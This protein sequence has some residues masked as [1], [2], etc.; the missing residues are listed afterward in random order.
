MPLAL[1]PFRV[2]LGACLLVSALVPV[3]GTEHAGFLGLLCL[4]ILVAGLPHGAFD[5]YIMG[6]RYS[7]AA[8]A[9]AVGGYLGLIALTVLVWLTLPLVFLAG[10][11]SYSAYHFGDSDWPSAGLGQKLAWGAAIVGLPCLTAGD[12]VS[13]LFS[14]I[15]GIA[16]LDLLT[17]GFGLL[18]IP[19]TAWCAALW[20]RGRSPSGLLLICYAAACTLSGPLAA[21]ACY[22][23][24]LHSPFHLRLWQQRIPSSSTLSLYGLSG[25]VLVCVGLVV[26]LQPVAGGSPAA[27]LVSELDAS[28]LR[29]TFVAL[30]ALTVP[31][32]TLL[33]M[34]KR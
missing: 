18:A 2:F 29:Y 12:Q 22:F 5:L 19:A 26:T 13:Q 15:T 9:W 1:K 27:T 14:I 28:T 16:N 10:F 20:V 31:H 7:G 11:L 33:L 34:A 32:M 24:C 21:F 23:A 6:H 25:V 3:F 17:A 8:L 30:A 4:I